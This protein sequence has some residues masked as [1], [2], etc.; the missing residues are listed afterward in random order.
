MGFDSKNMA[1]TLLKSKQEFIPNFFILDASDKYVIG[2]DNIVYENHSPIS[3]FFEKE[4]FETSEWG[5]SW[6]MI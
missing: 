3:T 1:S 6:S 4:I 5:I 2:T